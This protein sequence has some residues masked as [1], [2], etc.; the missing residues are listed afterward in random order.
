MSPFFPMLDT[1]TTK[2]TVQGGC[3]YLDPAYL[4][5]TRSQH[6]AED[7]NAVTGGDTDLGDGVLAVDVGTVSYAGWDTYIGGIVEILHP[8]GSTSG[9][10]HLRDV[11]VRVGQP[12][13]GG[14]LI[15][16][17]GKGAQLN[18]KAHLHFYVKKPGVRLAPNYWPSTHDKNPATCAA[19]IRANYFVPSEWLRAR[20]AKRTLADLQALRGTPG[21]VLVNDV[22]VTGQLVQR[23]GNGLTVDARTATVRVYA[24]DPRPV[25]AVPTLPPK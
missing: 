3:G 20:G 16:Q 8:D 6:P 15:G 13:N 17:V 14:D 12:V 10:W 19:F 9:Y 25:P 7:F 22:E 4:A 5:A 1:P 23:P 18:M 11:H 2:Y 24:N 21:R